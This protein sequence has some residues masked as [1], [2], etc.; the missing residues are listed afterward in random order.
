M[1]NAQY[2]VNNIVRSGQPVPLNPDHTH[3]IL[4]D[5]GNRGRYGGVAEFRAQLEKKISQ[6]RGTGME[7]PE[8]KLV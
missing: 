4:V 6:P 3:F 5:D 8:S 7:L 1:W 2:K